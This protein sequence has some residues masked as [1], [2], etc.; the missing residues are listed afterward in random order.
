V[1][2]FLPDLKNVSLDTWNN[3]VFQEKDLKVS[4]LRLDK[5]HP[6][7]SGNKWFKLKYYLEEAGKEN[8]N[9]LASFGGAYS[10]HLLAVSAAAQL[11]GFS[12]LGFVRG[13]E[14]AILSFTL[15]AA[16]EQGMELRFSRRDYELKKKR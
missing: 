12:S 8:K 4:V 10:N 5:I 2:G 1:T 9:K 16:K 11:N 13:E 6:L 7:I 15:Q 14:P 3:P